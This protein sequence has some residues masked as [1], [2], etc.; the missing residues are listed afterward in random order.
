MNN[1]IHITHLL[2]NIIIT[3]TTTIITIT[4]TTTI[5]LI[6]TITLSSIPLTI[7]TMMSIT[8]S[9]HYTH[10]TPLMLAVRYDHLGCVKALLEHDANFCEW[11]VVVVVGGGWVCVCM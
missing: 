5:T 7:T 1:H 9:H 8:L 6:I 11:V 2:T 4:L 10:Q 3:L